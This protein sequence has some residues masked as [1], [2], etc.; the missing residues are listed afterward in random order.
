MSVE[1]LLD[2]DKYAFI[3]GTPSFDTVVQVVALSGAVLTILFTSK[4]A[5]RLTKVLADTCPIDLSCGCNSGLNYD[6]SDRNR[7]LLFTCVKDVVMVV[8]E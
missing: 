1:C 4:Q 3:H 5:P 6:Y 7:R 8:M 2:V